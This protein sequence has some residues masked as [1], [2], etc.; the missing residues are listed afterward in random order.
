MISSTFGLEIDKIPLINLRSEFNTYYHLFEDSNFTAQF[1]PPYKPIE[2]PY[3]SWYGMPWEFLTLIL[4][5]AVTGIESY[6]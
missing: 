2:S 3:M 4:Q 5:R 6:V 1:R